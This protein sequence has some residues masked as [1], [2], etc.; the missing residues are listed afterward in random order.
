L[1]YLE[2]KLLSRPNSVFAPSV[3]VPQLCKNFSAIFLSPS[4]LQAFQLGASCFEGGGKCAVVFALRE[5]WV[6]AIGEGWVKAR[7][8]R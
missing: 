3:K 6:K 2:V 7:A 1:T 4:A 8:I 5:G